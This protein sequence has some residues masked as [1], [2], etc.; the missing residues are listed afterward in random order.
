MCV[1]AGRCERAQTLL[2]ASDRAATAVLAELFGGLAT[3][4]VAVITMIYIWACG[5]GV[6]KPAARKSIT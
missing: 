6:R 3:A 2:L 5:A 1:Q 4:V